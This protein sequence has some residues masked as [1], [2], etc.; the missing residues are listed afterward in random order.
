MAAV[1]NETPI[2]VGLLGAGTVGSQTARLI[3]EQRDELAARVGR[4]VE[5]AAVACLDPKE[6]ERFPWIDPAIVTTD[7]M[8]VATHSDIV[9]E[10]IGGTTAA[11]TFVMAAIESGASVVTANKALLAKYGPEIYAAAEAKGVDIYF[12]AA[13][14]G[15]IPF[16]RPLRE[17]LVGDCVTSMLGIVNG[18][19]NYI[20]DEMTTKGLD[21]DEV[22]KDAQAKG[23]AEADPT[24]DI[25]GHDA[26]NKA[27]IMA[28]LGFHTP[29]SIDDVTVE[30]ITR[31]T[32]DDIAAATAEHKVIKLLAVVENGEA[33]VS[34]RVY[35]ALLPDTHPLAAVH[36]SFNAVFVKAE[37][38]DDL[39]FYG[40]GAGGAPTASAVVGDVVT[41]ARHIAAGTTG[42]SIP[43]YKNLPLA[44]ASASRA[45]FAVRFLIHDKP[46]VLAAVAGEF[47]RHGVSINAVNGDL[48]PSATQPGYDGEIQQLRIVTHP[49]DEE[50]LRATVDAV[51][52]LDAVTGEPSILR[53][54]D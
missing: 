15:A 40:R 4:P 3:V 8:Q 32:A 42:P 34:A 26:A 24:G 9:V 1:T 16:L 38:A 39:M 21:F 47:A 10:L 44:P 49:T 23:Y 13:V 54:I 29:V 50:T 37:A 35:P 5:L 52:G 20:L 2:R 36:G 41:V 27:A 46:G 48:K 18:T 31:I 30:G 33:G 14:G 43:L 11:R 28:T 51:R 17:S 7:T 25:E 19:T 22:L 53:V 6:T 45:A 12:E